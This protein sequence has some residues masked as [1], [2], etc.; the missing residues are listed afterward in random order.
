MMCVRIK[1]RDQVNFVEKPYL[2]SRHIDSLKERLMVKAHGVD[3]IDK[4]PETGKNRVHLL[5][6]DNFEVF[7]WVYQEFTEMV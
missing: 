6:D 4:C 3:H 2:Y 5:D 7:A 1:E